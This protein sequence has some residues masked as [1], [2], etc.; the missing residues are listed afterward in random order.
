MPWWILGA[1]EQVLADA[2][3]RHKIATAGQRTVRERFDA[4][5]MVDDVEK[6]YRQVL[7]G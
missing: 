6:L 3:L 2:G 5:R 1:I 7:E 4:E